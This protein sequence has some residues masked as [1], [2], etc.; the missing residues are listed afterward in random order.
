[1][2]KDNK[3]Y[4]YKSFGGVLEDTGKLLMS[5][6]VSP[7]EH[8][9]GTNFVENEYNNDFFEE[10]DDVVTSVQGVA[11]DVL[12]NAVAPGFYGAGKKALQAG[13][14]GVAGDNE[15]LY[16][17]DNETGQVSDKIAK[18]VNIAGSAAPIL[19]SDGGSLT[20]FE[21]GGKHEQNPNG[22][23]PLGK[24]LVEEGETRNKNY[25]F[26]DRL[27]VDED[28]IKEFSLPKKAKGKT[29]AQVSKMFE[30]E[31]RQMDP[32]SKR[33]YKK[34]ISNLQE[35]QE[36]YK[37]YHGLNDEKQMSK[38]GNLSSK[39]M[40][41][42]GGELEIPNSMM[43]MNYPMEN[44]NYDPV[45]N[46][47]ER[48]YNLENLNNEKTSGETDVSNNDT[49]LKKPI[50]GSYEDVES[51]QG[52]L[53]SSDMRYAPI[54]S[55]LANTAY[56][57]GNK[58]KPK[59]TGMFDINPDIE[60]NYV[61]RE[62]IKRSVERQ[63]EAVRSQLRDMSGGRAGGMNSNLLGSQLNT[64]SSVG[65]LFTE[66]E[67]LDAQEAARVQNLNFRKDATN[68]RSRMRVQQMNDKDK[69]VYEGMLMDQMSQVGQNVGN[70]GSE[71][72]NRNLV[73][74][75]PIGYYTDRKGNIKYNKNGQ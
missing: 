48:G 7:V 57:L 23:I 11:T 44:P 35:A 66:I 6:A 52:G 45:S 1:M 61:D 36:A 59:S 67:N 20:S 69:G 50:G 28:L 8:L 58:P 5:S 71:E 14:K 49:S 27:K 10:A 15:D 22:G 21:E 40:Y 41:A 16:K 73:E 42:P 65:K 32:I 54:A 30:D 33:G 17:P 72:M 34:E 46:L 64:D 75:L 4:K 62:G 2:Y 19:M 55:N 56:L 39:K 60:E 68:Q 26:S 18:G 51:G 29:F 24:N 13:V 9:T 38:G 43:E 12:G 37:N 31:D 74:G 70:V 25:I 63:G 53:S 3:K 47:N